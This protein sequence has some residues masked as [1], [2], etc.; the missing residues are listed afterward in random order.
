MRLDF[1]QVKLKFL[2]K[3]DAFKYYLKDKWNVFKDD[4]PIYEINQLKCE[5]QNDFHESMDKVKSSLLMTSMSREQL[6]TK[7]IKLIFL[8]IL[9]CL[10]YLFFKIGMRNRYYDDKN[11]VNRTKTEKFFRFCLFI[12]LGNVFYLAYFIGYQFKR[13]KI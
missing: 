13:D 1:Y 12:F 4:L 2:I 11:G 5:T 8:L 3:L 10:T 7:T 9:T 6:I